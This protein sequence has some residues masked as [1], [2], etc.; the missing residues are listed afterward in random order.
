MF[1]PTHSF[2][3]ALVF[4]VKQSIFLENQQQRD[5]FR[6]KCQA[7]PLRGEGTG[8]PESPDQD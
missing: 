8:H 7:R 3:T 2:V 5:K 6:V 1:L 4:E